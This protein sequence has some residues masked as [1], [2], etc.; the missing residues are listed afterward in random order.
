MTCTFLGG[1]AGSWLGTRAYVQLGWGAVCGLI[2]LAALLALAAYLVGRRGRQGDR[3]ASPSRSAQRGEHPC[4]RVPFCA[5]H[6]KG[7]G[8]VTR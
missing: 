4:C 6:K 3:D 2:A 5:T 7:T 1:S 8:Q